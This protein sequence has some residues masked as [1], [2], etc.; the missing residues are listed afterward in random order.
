M[1]GLLGRERRGFVSSTRLVSLLP[2]SQIR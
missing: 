2:S 1:E